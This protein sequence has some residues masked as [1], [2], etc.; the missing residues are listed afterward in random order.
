[1][2]KITIA[3]PAYGEVFYAPYVRSLYRLTQVFAQ[4]KWRSSLSYVSYADIVES[5]NYLLTQWFDKSDASHLLFLDADMGFAP[6]LIT[7]MMNFGTPVV[8]VVYPKR[9]IDLDRLTKL[10]ASGDSPVL[11]LA[12][13]HEFIVRNPRKTTYRNGFIEVDG[14]GTGIMLIKRDCVEELLRKF[15]QLSDTAAK[16]LS[17]L[18]KDLDRLIRAFDP[19]TVDGA[20][21]SEDY[22]FCHRWRQCGGEVWASIAHE[23]THIGLH[24]FKGRYQDAQ[25]GP[26]VTVGKTAIRTVTGRVSLPW[27]IKKGR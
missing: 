4:R 27:A 5:R 6:E 24:S 9:Q 15:P 3:T 19:V 26:R 21:L 20:R 8:G 18:A 16:K 10:A 12:R 17:P 2:T 23:I 11:A 7:D 14:C 22:S 1:M 13:S 25:R